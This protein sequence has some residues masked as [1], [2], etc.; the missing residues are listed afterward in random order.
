VLSL[1]RLHGKHLHAIHY[2][3]LIWSLVR[4]PG[5]FADSVYHDDLYPTVAFRHAY[6]RLLKALPTRAGA[7]YV[8]VLYLAATLSE[9]EVEVALKRARRGQSDANRRCG[10]RVGAPHCD[11]PSVE[12]HC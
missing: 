6:D 10:A 11:Q 9:V 1:S 8:R 2:R 5:A 3:H 7:E 4:K 12:R